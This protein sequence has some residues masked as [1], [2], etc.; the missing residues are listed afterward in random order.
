MIPGLELAA[1]CWQGCIDVSLTRK[2]FAE[3]EARPW[4]L[5]AWSDERNAPRQSI[6]LGWRPDDRYLG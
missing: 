2:P 1:L 5:D 6:V 3:G 4:D